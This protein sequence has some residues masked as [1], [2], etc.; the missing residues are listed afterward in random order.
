MGGIASVV[1]GLSGS[2]RGMEILLIP[3]VCAILL[4]LCG[5]IIGITA[6]LT[7]LVLVAV[8][9]CFRWVIV[10]LVEIF[11][12]TEVDSSPDEQSVQDKPLPPI[13]RGAIPRGRMRVAH[14]IKDLPEKPGLYRHINR[15]NNRVE[16]IGQTN[17]I[18]RRNREHELKGKLDLS[19]QK[20]AYAVVYS[21]AD[22]QKWCDAEKQ[23]IEKHNPPGNKCKGG[24]GRR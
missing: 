4:A 12:R 13:P 6:T 7:T 24:N 20:V 23:H 9:S 22:R 15:E 2:T 19:T 10:F 5:G 3:V 1:G 11:S 16:Y 18:K 21:D 14:Q 8:L 17:N